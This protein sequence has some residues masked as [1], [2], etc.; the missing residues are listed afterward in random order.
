MI[1]KKPTYEVGD[2]VRINVDF[3]MYP[4]DQNTNIKGRYGY[5]KT[6][7]SDSDISFDYGIEIQGYPYEQRFFR[8]VELKPV[9]EQ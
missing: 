6:I 1:K 7:W 9:K 8:E 4:Y 3:V 2:L 5:V